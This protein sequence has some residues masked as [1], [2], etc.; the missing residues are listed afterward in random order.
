MSKKVDTI[1]NG[2]RTAL[3]A[4]GMKQADLVEKTKIGKSS[5]STY[6]SGAYEPKQKNIYRIA[7]ALNVDEA[8]LMGFD[9]QMDR[10]NISIKT[11]LSRRLIK[12]FSQSSK[13]SNN[14]FYIHISTFFNCI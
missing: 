14:I 2:I 7:S 12:R 6:L 5:I 1:A 10:K 9:V 11:H 8:W 3:E 13:I 4:R